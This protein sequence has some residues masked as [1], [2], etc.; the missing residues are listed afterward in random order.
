VLGRRDDGL[1]AVR[2]G[3][4]TR[5][6]TPLAD[7]PQSVSV[8]T[9]EALALQGGASIADALRYVPGVTSNIDS[10]AGVG[11]LTMPAARVRGLPALYAISGLRTMRAEVP[12]DIAFLDR[13][14]VPKGPSAVI[15]GV[16][17]VGGRGGVV[18]LVRKQAEPGLKT[19]VAQTGSTQDGGTVRLTADLGGALPGD[20]LWRMVGYGNQ[21]GRTEGGY[22]RQ[23]SAGL[24]GALGWRGPDLRA[25]L[26]V[27]ADRR[28]TVPAPASR[29]GST[30]VG[31]FILDLPPQQGIATPLDPNDR[32]W[33]TSGDVEL[34]LDWRIAPAWRLN[35]KAR[36]EAVDND[37][38][39]IQPFTVPLR[40]QRQAWAAGSQLSLFTEFATGPARH[41]VMAGLDLERW[42]TATDGININNIDDP[43]GLVSSDITELRQ[44]LVLQDQV[45]MGPWR[46][47]L[48]VQ[49]TRVPLYRETGLRDLDGAQLLATN[50]D[51]GALVKLT[52]TVSVY[53][54]SQYTLESDHR[55][56]ALE[57]ADGTPVAFTLLRQGQAGARFDL[58]DG[59]LDMTIEAFRMRQLQTTYFDL[60][61][62]NPGRSTDGV[63]LE[64][65]GRPRP[66][67]D[68]SLGLTVM[69]SADAVQ[70]DDD[71]SG[72]RP[73]VVVPAAGVPRRSL[74][75]LVRHR[76]PDTWLRQARA[77]L[78]LRAWSSS[79]VRPPNP[80]VAVA[81]YSVSG[82]AQW[83]LSLEHRFGR[84]TLQ[85]F[86]NNVFDRQLYQ[87]SQEP[88]FLPL[89]PGRSLAVTASYRAE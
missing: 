71:G 56:F 49:R 58:L 48:G 35:W 38:R 4:A 62:D 67:M 60:G 30:L 6:N 69:R 63:E 9:A 41:R 1:R 82:G 15:G 57:L 19:Q 13:I 37:M 74:Q 39:R 84:W 11:G 40:R 59:R 61:V 5:D 87:V 43:A 70:G 86:V 24:L 50:W 22:T 31:N 36:A 46:L 23:G 53:A 88:R 3:T 52:D 89:Y 64:L 80:L 76:L 26:T 20:T 68:M 16:A 14:E 81:P 2:S 25:A 51:A 47:R 21:S 54:G 83:D 85:G 77:G 7:L 18:N 75:L 32:I 65:A 10:T 45:R 55:E 79:F 33:S 17:D 44:S 29:G 28:R 78:G 73:L 8:L 34:E 12:A 72:L 42:H 27:Q 66:G